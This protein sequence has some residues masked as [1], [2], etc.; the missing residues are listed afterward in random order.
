[1][2]RFP[3]GLA[4]L[5]TA[6]LHAP[7][8]S[9]QGED[10]YSELE[11]ADLRLA[12]VAERIMVSNASLCRELMPV[13]GIILH[14]ADQ[15]RE[16]VA[17]DRF[18]NGSL[19]V[20]ALLPESPASTAG[21][22]RDDGIIAIN[23]QSTQTLVPDEP[24]NLR[25]VGFALLADQPVNAPLVLR[26]AREGGERDMILDAP[27]GCRSLVEIRVGD[28][29]R[30][31]SNGIV[32]QV[33]YD[34]AQSVTDNE[35]AVIVAHELSHS[36][37]E[38]R[39]RKEEADIDIGLLGEVGRNQRANRQAEVEADRLSV[40]L[41]ANAGY[42]PQIAAN[43]WRTGSGSRLGSPL[44]GS[45]IY[46]SSTARAELLEGEIATYL[47]LQRGPSWPDHLLIMRDR[48]FAND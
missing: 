5:L 35:L 11:R 30:A 36:I 2:L 40:H 3:V 32:I 23:G 33:R 15:Y 27:A 21:L 13:T 10:A 6:V 25:E 16:G 12:Q 14:S 45:T 39:R 26:I 48:S 1:M 34:F 31:Q 7:P 41:L 22:A 28:G 38:H 18:V 19:A 47:P 42:D 4:L 17:D 8:L 44:L 24:G 46:P 37:L 9:A 43:F 29:P 20:A